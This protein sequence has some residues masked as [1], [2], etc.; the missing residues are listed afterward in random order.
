M[1]RKRYEALRTIRDVTA[2]LS[3]NTVRYRIAFRGTR[4][5]SQANGYLCD[6]SLGCGW[7]FAG[8]DRILC[9]PK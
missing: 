4:S 6:S 3:R 2:Q 8:N 1:S 9:L 7:R 5:D